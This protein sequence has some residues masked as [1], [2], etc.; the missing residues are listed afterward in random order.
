MTELIQF[1]ALRLRRAISSF[2]RHWYLDGVRAILSAT[3]RS[4]SELERSIAVRVTLH[5]FSE[6]LY[7]DWSVFGRFLGVVFRSLRILFGVFLYL[8]LALLSLSLILI[9]VVAPPLLALRALT[10]Y[11]R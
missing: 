4:I 9:W 2:F 8:F 3:L 10:T 11:G 7:Q 1:L 5:H 6:P